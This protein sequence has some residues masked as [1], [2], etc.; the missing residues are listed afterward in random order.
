MSLYVASN[1]SLYVIRIDNDG[2]ILNFYDSKIERQS[3]DIIAGY[4]GFIALY[5][6]NDT[7][8]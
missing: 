5:R 1:N 3:L 8:L 6:M 2:A 7:E 4:C